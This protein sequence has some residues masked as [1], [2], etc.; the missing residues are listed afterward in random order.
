M[1]IQQVQVLRGPN[2]WANFPVLEAWVDIEEL[3][4]SP[5][6]VIPG[7]NDR[8]M[9]WLPS[10]IEHRCSIGERG[11][12][13]ERL[14]TG[15]YMGHIL[16]HVTLELQSLA[17]TPVGFGRARE[18]STVG[19]YKVAIEY[20]D[21]SLGK[22][23][24]Q[25]AFDLC[26]AA[27]HDRPFD[28]DKE[29]QR[30]RDI[31]HESCLGPSTGAIVAAAAERGI[32]YLRLNAE[33]LVQLGYGANQ[34]RINAAETDRSGALAEMIAQDKQ[35]TRQLLQAVGA[36]VPEGRPVRDAEDAWR[37]AEELG[38]PVVI[39]PRFGN[40]GRGVGVNLTARD[41][42]LAAYAAAAAEGSEVIVEHYA[43]GD[44]YRLLVVGNQLVAASRRE[45]AHVIGDGSSTI[46][47]LIDRVNADPRRSVGHAT[48]LSKIALDVV[49]L[50]VLAEQGYQPESV[51]AAGAKALIRRNANLS[52]GGTAT[53]VTDRVHPEIAR[54]AVNAVR[55]VGLDVGGVDMICRDI[56]QPF[57][58]QRGVIVEINAQPGLR[59]HLHPTHG[60]ARPVGKAIV[61]SLFP[62]NQTGRIPI[63]AVTGVNGK[64]TTTRLIAHLLD[65]AGYCV[66]MTCTD[67]IYV[68]GHRIDNEDCSG[69]KSARSVL[70]NPQVEAAV[71][72][73]ARGGILREGLGFDFCDVGVVTNIGDGD[74]LGLSDIHT[75]EQLAK[76]KRCVVEAV[77]ATGAAVLNADDPLVADMANYCPGRVVYFTR[78]VDRA[79]ALRNRQGG[80]R[81]ATA[82]DG[83]LVLAEGPTEFGRLRLDDIPLTRNGRIG[84]Q[85]ENALAAAAAA[86]SLGLTWIQIRHGLESFSASSDGSPARF[87]VMSIAG[88]TVILDYGHNASSLLAVLNAIGDFP[89][90]RRSAVY[91]TVGDR[92][93]CDILKQAQLLAGAFDRVVLYE[94][95][96]LRGRQEGEIIRLFREGMAGGSRIT[97]IL[98]AQGWIVAVEE[99][100]RTAEPGELILVQAD[101]IDQAV[102][103][104]HR[105]TSVAPVEA[106]RVE[107]SVADAASTVI[108]V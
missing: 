100:L 43:A 86:W 38:V 82:H 83:M 90:R 21:E 39:K 88:T 54:H 75:T 93:D 79:N 30:L 29:V 42:I 107:Q 99:A 55:M 77:A 59:M 12:F 48:A 23:A 5:S 44:D 46:R 13:F 28:V 19:V 51:P 60:A 15:T 50:A 40:H 63:A 68:D 47:E 6:H 91:S 85:I 2:I 101:T 74:H 4:Q 14:R 69:P 103:H 26:L 35:L 9:S 65:G 20:K 45:P 32:P 7:F 105:L 16:E 102:D 25:S 106:A 53:D 56:T 1:K 92:R 108:A 33:S 95:Q 36:P 17:G 104:L 73:T 64:T 97:K 94:D 81:V 58:A 18:T 72:E 66:G 57:S 98:E 80:G 67:G 31:A 10:M 52:T 89:H 11:G 70:M 96:Y 34:R 41:Q 3:E 84:F 24:L 22:A 78:D 8:L 87:E 71:L 62:R 61:E 49:A 27:I 37:T 76:V